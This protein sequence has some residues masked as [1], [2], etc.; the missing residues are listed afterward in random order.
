MENE[1]TL[2]TVLTAYSRSQRIARWMSIAITAL[3]IVAGTSL[4]FIAVATTARY[5]LARDEVNHLNLKIKELND[6]L[7]VSPTPTPK[8]THPTRSPI[9]ATPTPGHNTNGPVQPTPC[10]NETQPEQPDQN[11]VSRLK[12]LN[13]NLRKQLDDCLNKQSSPTAKP[14]R[15]L[16][17]KVRNR[18]ITP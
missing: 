16:A 4:V 7:I 2:D 14:L 9:V 13:Q 15:P 11:E 1:K 12:E 17:N 6:K 5:Y 8:D 10:T 3:T 18:V